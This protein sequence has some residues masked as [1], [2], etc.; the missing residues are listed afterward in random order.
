MGAKL[1]AFFDNSIT[2]MFDGDNAGRNGMIKA[3][4]VLN[5][6]KPLKAIYLP[7][8]TQPE[9]FSANALKKMLY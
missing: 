6:K 4:N 7:E 8:N 5:E 3:I 2:I 1:T 9:H